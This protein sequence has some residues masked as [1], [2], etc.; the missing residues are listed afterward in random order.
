MFDVAE[1][2]ED[3]IEDAQRDSGSVVVEPVMGEGQYRFKSM[4]IGDGWIKFRYV[5]GGQSFQ[6]MI[7][8]DEDG[9]WLVDDE[10]QFVSEGEPGRI[11]SE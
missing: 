5:D 11:F 2:V 10:V 3:F 7:Y 4:E 6:T 1:L 8:D 9:I